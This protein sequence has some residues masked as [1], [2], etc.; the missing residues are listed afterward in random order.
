MP[1]KSMPTQVLPPQVHIR[2]VVELIGGNPIFT[3]IN[4]K[5]DAC[6]GNADIT[7]LHSAI[8]YT[9]VDNC[10]DFIFA[11]PIIDKHKHAKDLVITTS[12]N[13]K[14]LI[15]TDTKLNF[16]EISFQLV[17]VKESDLTKPYISPDPVLRKVPD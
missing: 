6:N 1:K 5:G 4:D 11:S 16:D 10:N 14:T 3:Y 9:L 2:V 7:A 15:M 13:R 17:V 12:S 8:C